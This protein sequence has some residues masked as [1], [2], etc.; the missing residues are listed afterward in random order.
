[1]LK[2]NM[3]PFIV[4]IFL[5]VFSPHTTKAKVYGRK[6]RTKRTR[7]YDIPTESASFYNINKQDASAFV[8]QAISPKQRSLNIAL[9]L[10]NSFNNG[11]Y[12][13]QIEQSCNCPI[14]DTQ[15][16]NIYIE[17]N[18]PVA[19]TYAESNEYALYNFCGRDEKLFNQR[20]LLSRVTIH[21]LFTIIQQSI[22]NNINI[23]VTYHEDI[24]IPISISIQP[25]NSELNRLITI[26]CI[27]FNTLFPRPNII[28]RKASKLT[29]LDF[30]TNNPH[31]CEN[32]KVPDKCTNINNVNDRFK[33]FRVT[34]GCNTCSCGSTGN[35]ISCTHRICNEEIK[36]DISCIDITTTNNPTTTTN[37]PITTTDNPTATTTNS[38]ITTT[39]NVATT[40]NNPITTTDNSITT[41]SNINHINIS[42]ISNI[43]DAVATSTN[44]DDICVPH[45]GIYTDGC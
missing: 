35:L 23:E 24:G 18:I 28:I 8:D 39:D 22:I 40:T 4:S 11:F 26:H 10:F 19:S 15:S 43:I 5:L 25:L 16:M 20:L 33:C 41:T 29:I 14:C 45:C 36:T 31:S 9:N 44:A 21:D 1:M 13:F 6:Y 12:T 34:D 30:N 38:P 27:E 2:K 42:N 37:S 7:R 17:D 32:I 3:L